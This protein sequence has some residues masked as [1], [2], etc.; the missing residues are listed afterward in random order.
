MLRRFALLLFMF[1][2]PALLVSAEQHQAAM[3]PAADGV[4][5]ATD[6]YLPDS[7]GPAFPVVLER[8]VYPRPGKGEM[9]T[10]LGM[11]YVVQSTRGRFGSEGTFKPFADD[12]W[13]GAQDGA[14]TVKWVLAQPWCNGKVASVGTSATGISAALLA[15]ATRDVAC[16]IFMDTSSSAADFMVYQGGVFRK[17]LTEGWLEHGVQSADYA[18]TWN[19]IAPS[20]P[21][22]DDYDAIAKGPDITAPG[23]H[24]GGWWDIFAGSTV[25][26][27][28]ARQHHGGEGAKGNQK[29]VMRPTTHGPWGDQD[30]ALPENFDEFRVTPYRT[31]FI[32]HWMLGADT[33]ITKQ[34]AV[35]YY[36]IGDDQH[37]DGPGWEWRTAD[38]WPPY[39]DAHHDVYLAPEGTL[40]GTA[41]AAEQSL[42]FSFD[43]NN[44]VPTVGGQNLLLPAGPKDQRAVGDRADV[45]KFRTAE[46]SAPMETTGHFEVMLA[47][48]SD[49]PD[50]DFTA[51]L[52]DI[53]PDGREILMLDSIQRVKYRSGGHE[54]SPVLTPG[55]VVEVTIDLGH[56][57]W[58]FNKGHRVGLHISSSNYPRFAVNPNT[59]EDVVA[60]PARM[61]VAKNRIHV[62][63][64]HG[65]R[66]V[67]PLRPGEP[68]P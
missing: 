59:G 60:D 66:L 68:M 58:V 46:L 35:N 52:V 55:E 64:A 47:V 26:A 10:K 40:S 23:L 17:A 49:A 63:G 7:G 8:S 20:E 22:W 56:I 9:W 16:Q 53:Y 42:E 65:S 62:G 1:L 4:K 39:G 41:P 51:K 45:V 25:N 36:V 3:V 14:A 13:S 29:L 24:V 37:F 30:L 34:P 11:A 61:R 28:M 21:Y 6:V 15:P 50:T 38:D 48:S 57:S 18:T 54:V 32:T 43:P 44:P 31:A 2:L 19:A 12:G 5:L 67:L 27:F 33:G